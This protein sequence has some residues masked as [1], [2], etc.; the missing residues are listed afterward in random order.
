[1]K[2]LDREQE[3]AAL[4]GLLDSSRRHEGGALVLRAELGAGLSVLLDY[5]ATSASDMRIARVSGIESERQLVFGGVH[6]LCVSMLDRLDELPAAQR[7]AI[8]SA[9]DLGE[10]SSP[11]RFS[12]GCAV[13]T[14]LAAVAQEKP[15]LCTIDEAQWLDEASIDALAF[16]A[17]RVDGEAIALV[18]AV[19]ES[20]RN[21]ISLAGVPSLHVG[22]L[23]QA[24]ARELLNTVVPG[25]L[26]SGVRE[27]LVAEAGGVPLALVELPAQLTAE[28]LAGISSLPDMLPVGDRVRDE[29][30][31]P[32]R[33]MPSVT[34]TLLLLAAAEPETRTTLLW[35]AA[36]TLGISADAATPAETEGLLQ[37]GQRVTFRHPLLRLAIY[38][39]ASA[40]ERQ[41][42]HQALA[43]AIDPRVDPNRRAWH[44]AAASLVPDEE[45]A[46]D[47]E[48]AADRAKGRGDP[49]EAASLLERAAALSSDPDSCYRRTLSAAQAALAAG[50]LDRATALLDQAF[51]LPSDDLQRAQASRL[52]GA[53]ALALGQGVDRATTLLRAAHAFESLDIRLAR[54]TYLEALESA[55]YTARFGD[56]R[57]LL[58]TAEAARSAPAALES[59]TGNGDLLLDGIASLI[60]SGHRVAVP[61]LRRAIQSLR[62][63]EEPRWLAL[64]SLAA[65]EMCDDEALHDLTVRQVEL[66]RN[67]GVPPAHTLAFDCLSDMD[68]VVSGRFGTSSVAPAEARGTR[69]TRGDQRGLCLVRPAEL[70]AS[71]W[72]GRSTEARDLAETCMRE[73]FARELGLYVAVAHHALAVLEIG[74][75]RYEAALAAAQEVCGE[76]AIY[77]VTATL[78]ELIEAAVRTGERELAVSAARRLS[79]RTLP[80]G[81]DWALGTLERSYALL[82]EGTEAENLYRSAVE[83]LR[84]SRAAP[85]LARAHLVYGE[86]LRRERRRREAR[87][88]LRTARDMFVFMGARAFA[89]RARAELTATG[90]HSSR[91]VEGSS[92]PLTAQETRIAELVGE[93]ASNSEIAVQLFIS[94]R[95]VEYHLHKVFRKLGVNSRTQLARALLEKRPADPEEVI[96]PTLP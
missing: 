74:L 80:S 35:S 89:E 21:R 63:A 32:L 73:A 22:G 10:G 50:A 76:T 52:R 25:P 69:D 77:V 60:M 88:Q 48:N 19:H 62:E 24:A 39:A 17:R 67:A 78:P 8:V 94:P 82:G 28:Q 45:V 92:E 31:R 23:P 46:I 72:R 36:A 71:A 56:D 96:G 75:G 1:M 68:A 51:P 30:L 65:M 6:Q 70:I 86:W 12:V 41:R 44:R 13:H 93:G 66:S 18:F 49:S 29:F 84:R 54:E 5:A 34:K 91:R 59:Q 26:D 64:G 7:D 2:M 40:A 37:L 27:R 11:D 81:T 14:L 9:C 83:H 61:A 16:V 38:E 53:I 95:T 42:A 90:E 43:T 87:E 15:L 4:N 55:I 33:D 57:S 20:I 79:E 47:L 3:R 85:Q 58:A